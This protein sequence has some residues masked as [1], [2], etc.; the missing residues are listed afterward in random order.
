MVLLPP[1]EKCEKKGTEKRRKC[2][3]KRRKTKDNEGTEVKKVK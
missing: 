3:R 2:K 1:E